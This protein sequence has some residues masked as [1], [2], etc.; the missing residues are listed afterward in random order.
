MLK[1]DSCCAGKAADSVTLADVSTG[2][3][4]YPGMGVTGS[5]EGV[6]ANGP[7]AGVIGMMSTEAD[8]LGYNGH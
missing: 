1:G 2:V 6:L 4:D 5:A 8:E 7:D 3:V